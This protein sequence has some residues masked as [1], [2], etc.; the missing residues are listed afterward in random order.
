MHTV[1]LTLALAQD[2]A[3]VAVPAPVTV[4][5]VAYDTDCKIRSEHPKVMATMTKVTIDGAIYPVVG[6]GA[7]FAFSSMLHDCD[8]DSAA[9]A[10]DQWRQQRRTTNITGVVGLLVFWPL[11]IVT[12]F[13]AV[14]AG[15][16]KAEMTAAISSRK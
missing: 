11:L 3:Q 1:F 16:H 9:F 7:R 5:S 8:M 12:P 10:F 2:P 13:S 14:A 15:N 4:P 6:G